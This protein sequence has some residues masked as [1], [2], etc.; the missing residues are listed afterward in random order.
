MQI[1]SEANTQSELKPF[2]HAQTQQ[3]D[4]HAR[5]DPRPRRIGKTNEG[6]GGLW[7]KRGEKQMY[8]AR[9][10]I[11]TITLDH[12]ERKHSQR[13]ETRYTGRASLWARSW[14]IGTNEQTEHPTVCA[15][16]AECVCVCVWESGK[17]WRKF[18]CAVRLPHSVCA[19]RRGSFSTVFR[20]F[21]S[22]RSLRQCWREGQKWR[23]LGITK[24]E[25]LYSRY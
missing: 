8:T 22:V 4:P 12:Y 20:C 25:H 13:H 21:K 10:R 24:C 1:N 17:V 19:P 5:D 23:D 3:K 7:I 9:M 15:D 2:T 6:E 18:C 11:I 14:G 16:R